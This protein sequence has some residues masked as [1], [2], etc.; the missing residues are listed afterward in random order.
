MLICVSEGTQGEKQPLQRP[1]DENVLCISDSREEKRLEKCARGRGAI[2]ELT[3]TGHILATAWTGLGALVVFLKQVSP[4]FL[5]WFLFLIFILYFSILFNLPPPAL[6]SS[7]VFPRLLLCYCH[8]SYN[9]Q[10]DSPHKQWS[11]IHSQSSDSV[12][13]MIRSIP[14]RLIQL[15]Q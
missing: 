9:L 10:V 13:N 1:R 15:L 8:F 12:L 2:D 11:H 6:S 7:P 5:L 4:L 14:S 3:V